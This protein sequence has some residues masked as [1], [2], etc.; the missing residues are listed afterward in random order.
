VLNLSALF[1]LA[2]SSARLCRSHPPPILR[3]RTIRIM[4]KHILVV[5]ALSPVAGPVPGYWNCR[6]MSA[7]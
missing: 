7:T 6:I 5:R 3:V 2:A 4:S 1:F